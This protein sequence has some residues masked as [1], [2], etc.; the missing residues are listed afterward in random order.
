[1]LIRRVLQ[2]TANMPTRVRRIASDAP[3]R[4]VAIANIFEHRADHMLRIAV[5][6][7]FD[8]FFNGANL[9]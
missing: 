8:R 2:P 6:L 7:R 4:L 3:R 1:M 5:E 9:Q